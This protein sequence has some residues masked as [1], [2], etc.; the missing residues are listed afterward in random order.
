MNKDIDWKKVCDDCELLK[1]I[2]D[3]SF[4]CELIAASL[5][6]KDPK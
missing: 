3:C 6:R 1:L 2:D 5:K 4:G